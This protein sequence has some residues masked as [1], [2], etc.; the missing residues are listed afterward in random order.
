M[1]YLNRTPDT[2]CAIVEHLDTSAINKVLW[3]HAKRS[4]LPSLA[5]K[6]SHTAATSCNQKPLEVHWGAIAGK[7]IR[8]N[9]CKVW[10]RSLG[11]QASA[12]EEGST[13]LYG[14]TWV[15]SSAG[16]FIWP[17]LSRRKPVTKIGPPS[18]VSL[19]LMSR[20]PTPTGNTTD[21]SVGV[22]SLFGDPIGTACCAADHIGGKSASLSLTTVVFCSGCSAAATDG[23]GK[24]L[25]NLC[26]SVAPGDWGETAPSIKGFLGFGDRRPSP[27][28]LASTC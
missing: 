4:A 17:S 10:I 24:T 27:C 28:S 14:C 22:D 8:G 9:G 5:A 16:P 25:P 19:A 15:D 26:S 20:P 11:I 7:Y 1:H 21:H 18:S 12:P 13:C 6:A 2:A 23:G 3:K